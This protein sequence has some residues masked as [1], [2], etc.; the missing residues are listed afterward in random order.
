MS[1]TIEWMLSSMFVSRKKGMSASISES[2]SRGYPQQMA[3][4]IGVGSTR[5]MH[6]M[7]GKEIS[8][9]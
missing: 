1:K 6:G 7:A 4:S 2:G 9:R 3:K 8:V 5:K